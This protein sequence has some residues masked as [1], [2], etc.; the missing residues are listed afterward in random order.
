MVIGFLLARRV[1]RNLV[2]DIVE[3]RSESPL[4]FWDEIPLIGMYTTDGQTLY[5]AI[6]DS[7]NM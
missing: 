3:A 1:R 5:S 4:V 7:M 2:I 6:E